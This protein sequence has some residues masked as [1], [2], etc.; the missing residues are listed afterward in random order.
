MEGK[1]ADPAMRSETETLMPGGAVLS[2]RS[3]RAC[4]RWCR[5]ASPTQELKTLHEPRVRY[6]FAVTVRRVELDVERRSS[7]TPTA[8]AT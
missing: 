2:R 8:S 1:D 6:D 5:R 3:T 4:R 7:W